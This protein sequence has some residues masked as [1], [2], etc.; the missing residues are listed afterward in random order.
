[1][2]PSLET[3]MSNVSTAVETKKIDKK[4]GAD[5][6]L[7]AADIGEKVEG[8]LEV[9]SIVTEPKSQ[10]QIF[11]AAE[12]FGA[13]ALESI[14]AS[15]I[16]KLVTDAGISAQY[17]EQ[18]C[19]SIAILLGRNAVDKETIW[20]ATGSASS[21]GTLVSLEQFMPASCRDFVS[22]VGYDYE[23]FG[24]NTDKAFSD[25]KL[26]IV[27]S[28]LKWHTTLVP[29]ALAVRSVAQPHVRY[30]KETLEIY[31]L[32]ENDT[33]ST[34]TLVDLYREPEI[35]END[36]TKIVPL[37][38]NDSNNDY[39][40]AD[41]IIKFGPTANILKLSIDTAKYGHGKINRTDIVADGVELEFVHVNIKT[42]D[43]NGNA[44]DE[45]FKIAI[46]AS[47]GRL[48][49][50]ARG[51]S[52]EREAN[53]S[54]KALLKKGDVQA[55][56]TASALLATLANDEERLI[57]ALNVKP[58]INLRTGEANALASFTVTA[59][60][61]TGATPAAGTTTLADNADE[62][63]ACLVGYELKAKFD[64]Q[65]LRK[66]KIA[67]TT[68]RSTLSYDIP[69]GRNYVSDYALTDARANSASNVSNLNHLMRIGHDRF[70]LRLI[71]DVMGQVQ[72][73]NEAFEAD[74]TQDQN[75]VGRFYPAGSK[76]IPTVLSSTLDMTQI[77]SIRDADR[78]GDIRERVNSYLTAVVSEIHAKSLFTQQL[79][80]DARPTYRVI[81]SNEIRD[82]ILGR[83][84]T[85]NHLNGESGIVKGEGVEFRF[86]LDCGVVLEVITTTFKSIGDKMIIIPFL[87]GNAQSELN[88]GHNWD[89]GTVVGHYA[90]SAGGAAAYRIFGNVRELPVPSNVI[91]AIIDVVGKEE[92]SF[93]A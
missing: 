64:E 66:S 87:P 2:N 21:E 15:H 39:L 83:P 49:R 86:V 57:V 36:L 32:D 81:C 25:M 40:V 93:R 10:A 24:I 92:V 13:E 55:D 44:F 58:D 77:T 51:Q 53:I 90:N 84:H 9:T 8:F 42:D 65:N 28:L 63:A 34:T 50:V 35:V 19:E 37:T 26:S 11:V 3:F 79:S 52:V 85:H 68:L 60:N 72:A 20:N 46:P 71:E 91:G 17:V 1:M 48:T 61:A 54:H 74:P 76:V 12:S 4:L 41:G 5:L 31:N 6:I 38:A 30:E 22:G 73:E 18:A 88:F 75:E 59:G 33:K 23:S 47:R 67:C 45:V 89:H 62:T 14:D 7:L 82:I 43:G 78:A 56:G 69:S 27:V 16:T 70:A 80:T 29:R